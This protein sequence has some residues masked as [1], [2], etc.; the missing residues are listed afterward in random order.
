MEVL[1][2]TVYTRT[3]MYLDTYLYLKYTA[4]AGHAKISFDERKR[5][6]YQAKYGKRLLNKHGT[7]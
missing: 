7:I 5:G 3:L 4:I 1:L 2:Y 6:F